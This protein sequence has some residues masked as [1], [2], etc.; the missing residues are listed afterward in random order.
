MSRILIL[1]PNNL[2]DVVMTLPVLDELKKKDAQSH[3]T[4]FVEE[5]FEGGLINFKSCDQ[6]YKFPRKIVRDY[7][8]TDSWKS[9]LE[10]LK[11]IS[12]ELKHEKFEKVINLSQHSYISYLVAILK[13][14]DTTGGMLL[15]EGNLA[16]RDEWS[17]Y[18]YSIPFARRF[19]RFHATDIYKRIAG[20]NDRITSQITLTEQEQSKAKY[21]LSGKGLT[22]NSR[23]AIF[24]PGAAY[25]AKRWPVENFIELGEML[26][27]DGYDIIITG[28]PSEIEL[29]KKICEDLSSNCILSSGDLTFRETIALTSFSEIC[30]TGDTA[31]MHAAAALQKKVFAIFGSTNPV[32]T[33]PY[34]CDHYVFAGRCVN[35]PCFCN[36]CK[37]KLCL[38]SILPKDVYNVIRGTANE[39]IGLNCDVFK[40]TFNEAG[41]YTLLPVFGTKDHYYNETGAEL[42]WRAFDPSVMISKNEDYQLFKDESFRFT[43]ILKKMEDELTRFIIERSNDSIHSFEKNKRELMEIKGIGEFWTALLNIRLNS[44]PVIDIMKCVSESRKICIDT[45]KQVE[46]VFL[47]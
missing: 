46:S 34:G 40:T 36:D 32:E 37:S 2:G 29:G 6:I 15:R 14:L 8:R 3:I 31:L 18:L 19:N 17:Q 44:V 28:A 23:I 12:L 13:A 5:G 47:V 27:K 42:S 24:Q 35:R 21:Y 16:L 25:S 22:E 39:T 7:A 45:R 30:I 43:V 9:G 11:Q 38:K 26:I 4:F 33:G 20:V 10:L 41:L 1:L